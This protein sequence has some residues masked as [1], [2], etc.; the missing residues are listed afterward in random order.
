MNFNLKKPLTKKEATQLLFLMAVGVITLFPL[1]SFSASYRPKIAEI[2]YAST[3]Q[4]GDNPLITCSITGNNNVCPGS[5][6]TYS[7]P[8][9]MDT[10]SWSVIS[11]GATITGSSN[12]QIV[13]VTAPFG[14][15]PF[16]LGLTVTQSSQTSN[17][18]QTFQV[19]DNQV[20]VVTGSL[21]TLSVEGCTAA[22]AP[23][24]ATNAESLESM[25][26]VITDNCT[27]DGNLLITHTETTTS[28]CPL[29]M[30]RTY[31]IT[32]LCNNSVSRP[33]TI[34]IDD[35][36]GPLIT[37]N[38]PLLNIEGCGVASA[39]LAATSVAQLESM[40]LAISDA[41]TSDG[42]LIV[43]NQDAVSGTCPM[44]IS[45]TY[46]I[47]DM[48]NNTSTILQ[49]IQVDDNTPPTIT[50]TLATLNVS[51]CGPGDIPA[52]VSTVAQLESMG[53]VVTDACTSD[54]NLVVTSSDQGSTS[55]PITV[56]R[57]YYVTDACQNTSSISQI[58]NVSDNTKPVI[59]GNIA[60]TI[61]EG[62][63]ITAAPA[64]AATV[65]DL[66]SL[67]L[68]IYDDCT[69][70]AA[71]QVTSSDISSGE[72]PIVIQRTYKVT[73][74]CLNSESYTQT[75]K[76]DD[77]TPPVI[78]GTAPPIEIQ[79]CS[80]SSVPLPATSVVELES[81][82]F[83][84]T[85]NCTPDGN[86]VVTS[87]ETITGVCPIVVSRKYS[88]TDH[89]NNTSTCI[90]EYRVVDKTAPLISGF[91]SPIV[92]EGCTANDVPAAYNSVSELETLGLTI[93]DNCTSNKYLTVSHIDQ[94][95]GTC[96]IE[97]SRIYSV[98]DACNNSSTYAH[99]IY[100]IDNTPPVISA[101]AGTLKRDV[102]RGTHKY[103]VA[104]VEFDFTNLFDNCNAIASNN[105]NNSYTLS[106]V[107]LEPDTVDVIWAAVDQCQ[108]VAHASFVVIINDLP[109]ANDDSV[110]MYINTILTDT[111]ALN[112]ILSRDG[113]N[114][115]S[116]LNGPQHGLVTISPTGE[117]RYV[118]TNGYKGTDSFSYILCDGNGDCDTA[119]VKFK[120]R[121]TNARPDLTGEQVSTLKDNPVI[122]CMP[123][124]DANLDDMFAAQV[125]G[126]PAYGS[127]SAVVVVGREVCFTYT[128]N[129]GHTGNDKVIIKICDNGDPVLCDI[130]S[131]MIAVNP[132]SIDDIDVSENIITPN[133]DGFNET[134]QIPGIEKYPDNK[135]SFLNRWGDII[136]QEKGYNNTS[137]VWDGKYKNGEFV[138]DGTYFLIVE[139]PGLGTKRGFVV[140]KHS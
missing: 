84:I 133:G 42:N 57:T 26:L 60:E 122:I 11:G 35:N 4:D 103:T 87:I 29:V 121:E 111:L 140:V 95:S 131:S 8:V 98:T 119:F 19:F 67:G 110:V 97:V 10:Y 109:L 115:F 17:C 49:T 69:S 33:Q 125:L 36:T 64:P 30:T 100:V 80:V 112:D 117:F 55:C 129:P 24:A 54:G 18:N 123:I 127:I 86:L 116:L 50:G 94:S 75:I 56:T 6:N 92:V 61:I 14:C 23:A 31:T 3:C 41:C 139:I 22:D 47:K 107:Q 46:S 105:I 9:G 15:T 137:V 81:Y 120:I 13:V 63:S 72:C 85:D 20:P 77:N 83:T 90:H 2:I 71:L 48:C 25:G 53:V 74:L 32:D 1:C 88:V 78:A 58:F 135:V 114:T 104:G 12:G 76:I 52:P 89:C 96:P 38:L 124:T 39:P 108:N 59:S 68:S 62:C 44:L 45:R 136:W 134:Y 102:V 73:D 70:D 138:P 16:T 113:S 101:P 37:G 132:E 51:G 79:S 65:V 40:G 82:G 5:V 7:A 106:G 27:A 21:I 126:D 28:A 118:P 43:T 66:E 99:V 34:N 128:P 130:D 91:M 93:S